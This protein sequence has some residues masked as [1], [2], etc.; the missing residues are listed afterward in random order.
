MKPPLRT[1][2]DVA[3]IRVGLQDGT[4]DAIATD[5]A[6][7]S[8]EEKEREFDY[9]PFGIVGL[10]TALPVVLRLV[11]EGVLTLR[12]VVLKMSVNPAKIIG[13]SR[14]NLGIGEVADITVI[15]PAATWVVDAGNLKSKSRNTPFDGWK[16]RGRVSY[17]I[18]GGR[19]VYRG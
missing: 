15:N 2:K 17:T 14:G 9:A 7:H 5:H 1:A 16:M 10:E 3:A 18:V 11:E 19:V 13:I 6:P 12:D 4:I 8:Q